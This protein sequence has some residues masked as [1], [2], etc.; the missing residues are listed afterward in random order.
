MLANNRLMFFPLLAV[1]LVLSGCGTKEPEDANIQFPEAVAQAEAARA[2]AEAALSGRIIVDGSSTVY[3]L[4]Q[5][6]AAEF[7]KAHPGVDIAVRFSGTGGGF[8][9]FCAGE[10]DITG[11]SRPINEKEVQLCRASRIEY[12]ELPVA[13]DSIAVVVNP[14]NQFVGCLKL[15]E[16]RT[17]WQPAAEGKVVSWNQ[18]RVNFP[19]QPLRLFGPGRDSGTFD[20]FTLAVVGDEGR[21]RADYTHSEDDEVLVGGVAAAPSALGY[22]GYAYYLANRDRLK[23]VAVDNGYGCTEPSPA[24]VAD[25]SYQPLSRPIFIYVKAFAAARPDVKAFTRFY[26]APE[27]AGLVMKVGDVP[28]P[29]LS[30]RT[31]LS[32]FEKGMSGTAFGGTGSLIRGSAKGD[33]DTVSDIRL[34]AFR[35][36]NNGLQ[37]VA[38][39]G[40]RS[41]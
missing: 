41:H 23:L 33:F 38:M 18:I 17:M 14:Q 20:Y 3:P 31:A 29:V 16:L 21:S 34:R 35:R 11:A 5:L 28:L 9:K 27:N 30:L 40:R 19:A 10:T 15:S 24:T 8:K 4:S 32:R 1:V 7:Q 12:I 39:V 25:G 36:G 6:M 37:S 13:F 2:P 22:F 26:L